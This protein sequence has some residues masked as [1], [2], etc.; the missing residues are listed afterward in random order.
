MNLRIRLLLI[1][2]LKSLLVVIVTTVLQVLEERGFREFHSSPFLEFARLDDLHIF[3]N[4]GTMALISYDNVQE[5]SNL[6]LLSL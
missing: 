3:H 2:S 1:F 4:N 6:E 5:S